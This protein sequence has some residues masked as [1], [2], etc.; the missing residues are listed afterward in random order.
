MRQN[1]RPA[2]HHRRRRSSVSVAILKGILLGVIAL[3]ALLGLY[4][5]VA[6]IA[7]ARGDAI[8]SLAFLIPAAGS[9]VLILYARLTL[10][11]VDGWE[12]SGAAPE[13]LQHS[14]S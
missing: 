2:P 13:V 11:E 7:G 1:Q 14:E 8:H 10:R 12:D 3:C 6:A 5:V 4:S 9:V